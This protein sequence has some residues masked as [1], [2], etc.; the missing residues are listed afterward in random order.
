MR[1]VIG[2]KKRWKRM[3]KKR[4]EKRKE[5]RKLTSFP[6][7]EQKDSV[8]STGNEIDRYS[9]F[10]TTTMMTMIEGRNVEEN[11]SG[12]GTS[13][14]LLLEDRRRKEIFMRAAADWADRSWRRKEKGA[15]ALDEPWRR[16]HR[17]RWL[18]ST[19]CTTDA[20]GDDGRQHRPCKRSNGEN[21]TERG[22]FENRAWLNFRTQGGA[23]VRI[24]HRLRPPRS[25]RPGILADRKAGGGGG[26]REGRGHPLC[27]S[28]R[29]RNRLT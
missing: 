6:T 2:R 25:R 26:G 7:S 23:A 20:R 10:V 9:K 13:L 24:S 5:D 12:T 21:G 29:K 22:E 11:A 19:D 18:N 4:K 1:V 16:S 28:D 27:P 17:C 14:L 8:D 15:V 3:K